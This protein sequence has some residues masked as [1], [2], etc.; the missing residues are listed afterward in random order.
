MDARDI[1]IR[2]IVTEGSMALLEQ[3]KYVFVVALKAN[4]TQIRHAVEEIFNVKVKSVNTMRVMG[5]EKRMGRHAGR[6][7]NWKK[8]IVTLQPGETIELFEGI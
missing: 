2:P 6:T 1:I 8:A 3:Q 7:P 5:K 4:K